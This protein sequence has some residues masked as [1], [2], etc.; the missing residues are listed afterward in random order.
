[1]WVSFARAGI[2]LVALTFLMWVLRSILD[3]VIPF[4]LAG[5]NA[6]AA[7]VQRVSTYFGALTLDNLTLL[8]ALA[9]G[10]Y[11]LGRAATERNLG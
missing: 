11:L 4:A 8:V 2:Y 1:M 3:R 7:S 10:I 5:P 6:N 9:V